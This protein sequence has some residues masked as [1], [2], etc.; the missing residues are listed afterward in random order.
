MPVSLTARDV[1]DSKIVMIDGSSS[2]N[3]AIQKMVSSDTW[4]IIVEKEGLPMGVV[5]DRDILRRCL[6]KGSDPAKMKIQEIMTSPIISVG[7]NE[8]LGA[9]MDT[10]VQKNIR[11]VFVIESGKIVGKITQTKL[12]DDTIA[13]ME[14]L[15]SL[16]YQM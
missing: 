9:V 11:R 13:V 5:T 2:V 4:S 6:G 8:K 10:M 14:S 15:S 16:R 3:D 7:P 12:F 1:M